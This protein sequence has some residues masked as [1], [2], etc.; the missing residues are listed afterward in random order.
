M[1]YIRQTF[2]ALGLVVLL[3]GTPAALAVQPGHTLVAQTTAEDFFTRGLKKKQ[4]GDFAG[5]I[6]DYTRAIQLKPKYS[7]A[8][9]NRGNARSGAD[10]K[11]GAIADFTKAIQINADWGDIGPATA[12][13]NRGNN[14]YTLGDKQG[15]IADY[16]QSIKLD[17]TDPDAYYNRGNAFASL[18]NKKAAIADFQKSADLYRK[19]GKT[20]DYKDALARIQKLK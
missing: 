11:K 8:Y 16:N 6:A 20:A 5:A 1:D 18:R 12:Y 13:Y 2:A 14:K 3:G 19:A 15:A 17:S 9:N 7:L 4:A 10:D